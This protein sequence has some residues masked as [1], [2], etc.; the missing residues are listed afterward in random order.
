MKTQQIVLHPTD[1]SPN[2]QLACQ[3][4]CELAH[5]RDARLILLHVATFRCCIPATTNGRRTNSCATSNVGIY[6]PAGCCA[7]GI[8]PRS[9]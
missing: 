2:S 6:G 9:S 5:E 8:P 4:A 1:F 3:L 7:T